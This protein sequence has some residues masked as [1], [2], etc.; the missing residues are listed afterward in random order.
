M[1]EVSVPYW[2]LAVNQPDRSPVRDRS[3]V[4]EQEQMIVLDN[5]FT[6]LMG[7]GE[8]LLKPRERLRLS[9]R[10]GLLRAPLLNVQNEEEGLLGTPFVIYDGDVKR[11]NGLITAAAYGVVGERGVRFPV[12][13]GGIY[14]EATL[15]TYGLD[16]RYGDRFPTATEGYPGSFLSD[17]DYLAFN[18][19]FKPTSNLRM[20][21]G[22]SDRANRRIYSERGINVLSL[23]TRADA[24]GRI[25]EFIN[26]AKEQKY[27]RSIR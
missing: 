2:S 25:T 7:P 17:I 24:L 11:H 14:D 22:D 18:A 20:V 19:E 5:L 26:Q 9:G 16:L 10:H 13:T 4:V 6:I 23:D 15:Q 3:A 8:H 27:P 21:I 12:L 1:P